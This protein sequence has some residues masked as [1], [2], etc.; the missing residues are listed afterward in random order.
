MLCFRLTP[1]ARQYHWVSEFA[2]RRYQKVLSYASGWLS[3]ICWQSFVASDCMFAAQLIFALVQ[4][5]SPDFVV[6][7]YYDALTA[8]LIGSIVTAINVWGAK[9][10]AMLEKVFVALHVAAFF[11]VLITVA[12]ASPKTDA[13]HVFTSFTDNGG[14][15][16]LSMSSMSNSQRSVC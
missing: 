12:V 6:H 13:K 2:P 16:P 11:V 3:S 7:N 1:N 14:N 5:R 15:Y 4:L 8:I 10:L 9:K